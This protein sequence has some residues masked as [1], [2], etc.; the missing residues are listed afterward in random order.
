M[1][2]NSGSGS[3]RG[4]IIPFLCHLPDFGLWPGVD[5]ADELDGV[6]LF[7]VDEH[8]LHG[9]LRLVLNHHLDLLL[10]LLQ[11]YID[12]DLQY[13][14]VAVTILAVRICV[15]TSKEKGRLLTVTVPDH[16]IS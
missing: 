9:D 15:F 7:G 1:I 12:V 3:P 8:L 13:M 11:K 14:L 2:S 5:D 6:A 10:R 4:T 16:Y